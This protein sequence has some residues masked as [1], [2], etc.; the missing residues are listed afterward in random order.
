MKIYSMTAT[1]GKLHHDTLQFTDGLNIIHAPNEWGKSTW[2]A[3]LTAMLYGIDTRQQT[4]KAG[5][6]DKERFTPWSGEPM[7]GRMELNWNGRDITIERS[8][9]G[10]IPFGEFRAYETA[11]GLDVPE[12]TAANCGGQLLGVEKA[13]FTRAGFIRLQDMPVTQDDNLRRR[14]NSLVTTGD[15]SAAGDTLGKQLKD[16]K[17]KVRFNRSGLLPQAEYEREQ[18]RAQLQKQQE[19]QLQTE[20]ITARQGDLEQ[21]I[22]NL[23]NHADALRYESSRNLAARIQTANTTCKQ[24]QAEL[25][26]LEAVCKNLPD[27]DTAQKAILEGKSLLSRHRE[28]L[29]QQQAIPPKPAAPDVPVSYRDLT[30]QEAVEAAR[31]D[32]QK[33]KDLEKAAKM[34]AGLPLLF[35]IGTAI[36]LTALVILY[37]M[38]ILDIRILCI[39]GTATVL[40]CACVI[41]LS[42][43]KVAKTKKELNNI[44]QKHPGIAPHDWVSDAQKY[45]AAQTAYQL[46]AEQYQ[47]AHSRFANAQSQLEKEIS[48][49][50]GENTL[51]QALEIWEQTLQ[52]HQQLAVKRREVKNAAEHIVALQSVAATPAE[53]TFPDTLTY[54]A[55]ETESKLQQCHFEQKQLQIKLGQCMGQAD[56]IGQEKVLKAR[57]DSLSRR[58]IRLEEHYR[59]LEL[60]QEVLYQASVALQ[61]RFA[62]RISKR[63]Q[64]FF[65]R[66]TMG[67][68]QRIAL[69]DDLS[70]STSAENE[71]ILRGTQWRSDGTVDQLYLSLR[72]A[73]AEELTPHAPLVLDD[74]LIRFDDSRLDAALTLLKE[75]AKSKQVILFT[76]QSREENILGLPLQSMS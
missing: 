37:C 28:L 25:C 66:R 34:Q 14:L 29:T 51:E 11:T 43:G 6:A 23:E 18:L 5:L 70:I 74:A 56:S 31:A 20:Q 13:V 41:A 54:S 75:E 61:R 58:I 65:T 30:P 57:L 3:F 9:K 26:T 35:G 7:S 2:C 27:E 16:L 17:N 24:L 69:R 10:R 59:A 67:H 19:L 62:P 76:C 63:A 71:D 72:L 45:E 33:Q 49:Y 12:L 44:C 4:T 53:P 32:S 50:S 39:I 64:D 8:T 68:D 52:N 55:Q 60:A 22:K 47:H 15:E 40:L 21:E 46:D 73:V 48:A 1:F 38:G 42:V 36:V